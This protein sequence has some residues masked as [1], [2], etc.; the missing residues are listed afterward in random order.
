MELQNTVQ[1][2]SNEKL[3]SSLATIGSV[4]LK[5]TNNCIIGTHVCTHTHAHSCIYLIRNIIS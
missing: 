3:I 2:S 4:L 5:S 1:E